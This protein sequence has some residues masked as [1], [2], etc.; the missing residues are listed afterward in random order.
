MAFSRKTKFR[1]L[2]EVG[3]ALAKLDER[4]SKA[5]GAGG[6]F[7]T[8]RDVDVANNK[9][10]NLRIPVKYNDAARYS[11]A[12]RIQRHSFRITANTTIAVGGN[13][14]AQ[15]YYHQHLGYLHDDSL[16]ACVTPVALEFKQMF[17]TAVQKAATANQR[18]RAYVAKSI[19]GAP[20]D[21][22][23][24]SA[25]IH[26]RLNQQFS[27]RASLVVVPY[28]KVIPA[29][30]TIVI[31]IDVPTMSDR[32]IDAGIIVDFLVVDR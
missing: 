22:Y 14:L 27:Y 13:Q 9:I 30:N 6:F 23:I 24:A 32:W 11:D 25:T 15:S 20:A 1:N 2:D 26:S 29:N 5:E 19:T 7:E 18:I 17:F 12:M 10:R 16:I 8:N 3:Q 28:K 4:I 21:R 31:L